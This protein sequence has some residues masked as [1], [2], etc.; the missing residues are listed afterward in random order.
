MLAL[1]CSNDHDMLGNVAFT[2]IPRGVSLWYLP[3]TLC[4][5][6][7]LS[8]SSA[9]MALDEYRRWKTRKCIVIAIALCH[10]ENTARHINK[11]REL[12][13]WGRGRGRERY[14]T[15]KLITSCGNATTWFICHENKRNV[16]I[17]CAKSLTGFKLDARYANIMQHSLTWCTNERNMFC[18]TRWRNM[19]H[20]F[21]R[22]L[23]YKPVHTFNVT[24]QLHKYIITTHY[25]VTKWNKCIIATLYKKTDT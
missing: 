17:C 25:K 21:A 2:A 3:K 13:Q 24:L 4:E 18:P 10:L 8:P 15:I 16:G 6:A 7:I 12:Q 22:A 9:I 20:S 14:K 1:E 23:N 5:T 19:L 11:N